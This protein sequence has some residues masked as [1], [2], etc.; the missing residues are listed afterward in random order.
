[1]KVSTHY[2]RDKRCLQEVV[3]TISPPNI[4]AT[5][6]EKTRYIL[7]MKV[8]PHKYSHWL[9]NIVK[10]LLV[11]RV[12]DLWLSTISL[13]KLMLYWKIAILKKLQESE[14]KIMLRLWSLKRIWRKDLWKK[15]W[16][17]DKL[18]VVSI[19][20]P[21]KIWKLTML[22]MFLLITRQKDKG[23]TFMK[24]MKLLRRDSA[25]SKQ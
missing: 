3:F 23:E 9:N 18:Q 12:K 16:P 22:K 5:H 8:C 20:E 13:E 10:H 24:K 21:R 17:E 19:D 14:M 4:W 6:K 2:C 11:V 7:T 1:M 25:Q 15:V